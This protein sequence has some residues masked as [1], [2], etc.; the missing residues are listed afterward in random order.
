[1]VPKLNSCVHEIFVLLCSFYYMYTKMSILNCKG[2]QQRCPYFIESIRVKPKKV[3]K[4]TQQ[5]SLF[6]KHKCSS[7]HKMP[8]FKIQLRFV[9]FHVLYGILSTAATE[10]SYHTANHLSPAGIDCVFQSF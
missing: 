7:N 10:R 8:V 6:L 4:G 1:M 2:M 9:F 5:M 3:C